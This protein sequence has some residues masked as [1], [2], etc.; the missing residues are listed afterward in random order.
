MKYFT[1]FFT[2]IIFPLIIFAQNS[3]K[4]K[5]IQLYL[6]ELQLHKI[7][8]YQSFE[9]M[10]ENEFSHLL[11]L[12][13][14]AIEIASP[15]LK[16]RADIKYYTIFNNFRTIIR[17]KYSP[18]L[19]ALIRIPVLVKA[20]VIDMEEVNKG[21]FRQ[22]NLKLRPEH[23]IKGKEQFLNQPEFTVFYRYYNY[24]PDS[25]DYK[26]GNIYL[27]P[28]W[29]RGEEENKIFAVATWIDQ[30]GARFLIKDNIIYDRSNFFNM[31]FKIIWEDF[32]SEFM[33]IEN[34]IINEKD[35]NLFQ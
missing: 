31:G 19:E 1:T 29:D 34:K 35:L 15:E 24:V 7:N 22:I 33:D 9:N 17:K 6:N 8:S 16:E 23:I 30:Y 14:E 5:K 13:Y 11:K 25:I 20:K 10:N 4:E 3:E 12:A 2:L 26:I 27:F 28:L 32:V 21:G 18:L